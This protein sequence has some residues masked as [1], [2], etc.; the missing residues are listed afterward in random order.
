VGAAAAVR[1]EIGAP[2]APSELAQHEREV[3]M[4]R[5]A[6]GEALFDAAWI[7]GEALPREQASAEALAPA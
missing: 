4:V 6:C 3:A 5:A 2:R 1:A 7:A